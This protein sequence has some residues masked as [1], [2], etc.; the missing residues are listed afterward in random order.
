MLMRNLGYMLAQMMVLK[1]HWMRCMR[2]MR[3]TNGLAQKFRTPGFAAEVARLY[4]V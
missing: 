4:E 2:C 3:C 1:E